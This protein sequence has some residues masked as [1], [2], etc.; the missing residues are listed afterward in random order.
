MRRGLLLTAATAAALVLAA[1]GSPR[2]IKDGGTFRVAVTA[3]TGHGAIDPA[4]YD[5]ERRLLRPACGALLS[6]P[7]KPLPAGLRL[8]PDSRRGLPD[9]LEGREDV[10]LHDPERR[11]LL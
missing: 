9:D 11:A 6:Y 2:A 7:D 5:H 10:H 3:G 4:L 1:S 8:A